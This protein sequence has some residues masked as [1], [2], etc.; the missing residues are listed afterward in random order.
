MLQV[1]E[2]ILK[3]LMPSVPICP[4]HRGNQQQCRNLCCYSDAQKFLEPKTRYLH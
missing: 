4:L 2:F 3:A 1:V